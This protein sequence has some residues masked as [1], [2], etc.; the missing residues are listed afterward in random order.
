VWV[1]AAIHAVGLGLMC[2][3]GTGEVSDILRKPVALFPVTLLAP[4]PAPSPAR[5]LPPLPTVAWTP[6]RELP[7]LTPSEPSVA[8]PLPEVSLASPSP[9]R[10][11]SRV[12]DYSAAIP[13]YS[14]ESTRDDRVGDAGGGPQMTREGEPLPVASVG[15][16]PLNVIRPVYP[17]NARRE[18]L[19]GVVTIR[20]TIGKKG[21]IEDVEVIGSSGATSLD[22]AAL[23]AVREASFKPATI[24]GQPVSALTTLRIRFQLIDHEGPLLGNP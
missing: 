1:S 6:E 17:R 15:A 8:M 9:S 24:G 19:E 12:I 4:E 21:E 5:E 10:S 11:A 16:H 14:E 13:A 22:E 7:P 20:A 3:M 2:R 23:T 18:G